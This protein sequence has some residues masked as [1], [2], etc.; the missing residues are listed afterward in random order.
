MSYSLKLSQQSFAGYIIISHAPPPTQTDPDSAE[1]FTYDWWSKYY[2]SIKDERRTQKDYVAKNF[3]RMVIYPRELEDAFNKS[4][5]GKGGA[6]GGVRG[7]G[8]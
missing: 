7:F 4:V 3:D 1:K 6:R 5:E 8:G 2:Y